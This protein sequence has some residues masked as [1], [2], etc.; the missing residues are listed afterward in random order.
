MQISDFPNRLDSFPSD[1]FPAFQSSSPFFIGPEELCVLRLI[2]EES[3]ESIPKSPE[4]SDYFSI[5]GELIT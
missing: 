4:S 1:I 3:S 5:H 2:D